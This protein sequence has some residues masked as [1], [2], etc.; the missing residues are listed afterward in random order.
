MPKAVVP[1]SVFSTLCDIGLTA[2]SMR[3]FSHFR[4]ETLMNARVFYFD[5]LF[6]HDLPV[7]RVGAAR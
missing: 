4:L 7:G 5:P 1:F 3:F 2:Y 6:L